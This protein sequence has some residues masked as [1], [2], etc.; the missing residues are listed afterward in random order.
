MK[1]EVLGSGCSACHKLFELT[2]KAVADLGLKDEVEYVT[3]IRKIIEM[4][5]MQI[6]VLAIDGKP[7]MTGATN[8][9]EK[10]KSFLIDCDNIEKPETKGESG[11][12]CGGSC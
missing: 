11:C 6:P 5:V 9:I 8:D 2:K 3:D 1:I 10:V 4:G 7:V 12:T